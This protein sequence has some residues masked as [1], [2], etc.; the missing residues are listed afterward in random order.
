[1]RRLIGGAARVRNAEE[2]VGERGQERM[3][4]QERQGEAASGGSE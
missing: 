2:G 4:R 1:V 3:Q